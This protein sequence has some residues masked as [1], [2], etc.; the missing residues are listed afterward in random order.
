MY[1]DTKMFVYC[2]NK[3]KYYQPRIQ[4]AIYTSTQVLNWY[5]IHIYMYQVDNQVGSIYIQDDFKVQEFVM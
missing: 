3:K 4:N 5:T 2:V 1:I